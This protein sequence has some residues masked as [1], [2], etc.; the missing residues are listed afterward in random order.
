MVWHVY[1]IMN[2]YGTI[3]YVGIT[4]RFNTRKWKHFSKPTKHHGKFYGRM[5]CFMYSVAQFQ[6]KEEALKYELELHNVY[7]LKTHGK[8]I[9]EYLRNKF[10]PKLPKIPKKRGR[11]KKLR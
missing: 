2:F 5:D 7:G 10:G 8:K 4:H 11:P 1:E 3:E 9:S 6:N